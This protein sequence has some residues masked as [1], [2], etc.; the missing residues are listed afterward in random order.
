M[1][2]CEILSR[3]CPDREPAVIDGTFYCRSWKKAGYAGTHPKCSDIIFGHLDK[4]IYGKPY[5]V[6]PRGFQA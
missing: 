2:C 5:F 4:N 6:C 1:N 3:E